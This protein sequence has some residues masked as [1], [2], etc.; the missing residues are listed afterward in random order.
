MRTVWSV[1]LMVAAA[2]GCKKEGTPPSH[3][4]P[5]PAAHRADEDARSHAEESSIDLDALEPKGP[6]PTPTVV[7]VEH[8][9]CSTDHAPRPDRD[10]N[11]MC[12]IE[13]G[14]FMMGSAED[15]EDADDNERPQREVRVEP[16]F[17]D[18]LE[19]TVAQYAHFLTALG[20]NEACRRSHRSRCVDFQGAYIQI[21][22]EGSSFRPLAGQEK[23]P[24]HMVPIEGAQMYC[25]W[26]G[27]R[28][29]GEAEW[30]YAARHDPRTGNDLRFPWGDTF[31]SGRASC[32]ERLCKDGF[33]GYA[34]VGS[35][36]GSG[37]DE[38]PWGVL[39]MAGNAEELVGTCYHDYGTAAADQ[40]LSDCSVIERGGLVL[41]GLP[42]S[43]RTARRDHHSASNGKG[44]TGF[45][46]ARSL[47][48]GE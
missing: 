6:P 17:M 16:F 23:H 41:S 13:G 33:E 28:L 37:R 47:A 11:P 38:S 40:R 18:Q 39:D 12:K 46:C 20:T 31:E 9:D 24:V 8:G 44:H 25:E 29:P 1:A 42:R 14:T 34:P 45:R 35:H 10:P 19:V 26:A 21:E 32:A 22:Q 5:E 7:E 2:V 43:L 30:E 48:E 36:Y 4:P 3:D 27:K 15:D